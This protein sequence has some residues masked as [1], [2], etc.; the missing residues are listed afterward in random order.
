MLRKR[1]DGGRVRNPIGAYVA[2]ATRFPGTLRNS[3][4]KLGLDEPTY[5]SK[6]RAQLPFGRP[7]S[8]RSARRQHSDMPHVCSV[9][10]GDWEI[11]TVYTGATSIE[12]HS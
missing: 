4:F 8:G 10:G 9:I 12:R 1:F 6:A 2:N 3:V 7:A 11:F 5:Y